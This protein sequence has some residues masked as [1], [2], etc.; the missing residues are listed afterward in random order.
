[1]SKQQLTD[2][3]INEYKRDHLQF[4]SDALDVVLHSSTEN[5]IS[6]EQLIDEV[7][8]F[9]Q[10]SAHMSWGHAF[11]EEKSVPPIDPPKLESTSSSFSFK[12]RLSKSPRK[13]SVSDKAP[14][15]QKYYPEWIFH[16]SSVTQHESESHLYTISNI[17]NLSYEQWKFCY[18]ETPPE[19]SFITKTYNINLMKEIWIG[20]A[21]DRIWLTYCF[22]PELP[23]PPPSSRFEMVDDFYRQM[24]EYE[25]L[26]LIIEHRDHD[27]L[28]Y[29]FCT[30]YDIINMLRAQPDFPFPIQLYPILEHATTAEERKQRRARALAMVMKSFEKVN[31]SLNQ[32]SSCLV[33]RGKRKKA[34]VFELVAIGK[35]L[36]L[37][38]SWK[39]KLI[40]GRQYGEKIMQRILWDTKMIRTCI[41][42]FE[43]ATVAFNIEPILR[44]TGI[45]NLDYDEF[46][47]VLHA[48]LR[49]IQG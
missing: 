21:P 19:G 6:P 29:A 9:R 2:V 46:P 17:R 42:D 31:D 22:Q 18:D 34:S 7:F 40:Y 12:R 33:R 35:S 10:Q 45:T 15:N 13:R 11:K 28:V 43:P 39:K 20:F 14:N 41:K 26:S 49:D 25:Y 23:P 4:L 32:P 16:T 3:L 8:K 27:K 1:M 24:D 44:A 5:I 47:R 37:D 30:E 48:H 38:T 36:G